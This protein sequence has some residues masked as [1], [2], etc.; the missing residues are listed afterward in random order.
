VTRV[1]PSGD[2]PWIAVDATAGANRGCLYCLRDARK[3][4]NV[5]TCA[6]GEPAGGFEKVAFP[7]PPG[8]KAHSSNLAL[9]SDGAVVWTVAPA[10]P[11]KK[12][13]PWMTVLLSG[14]GGHTVSDVGKVTLTIDSY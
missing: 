6:N 13:F 9:L 12:A 8:M 2:R 3:S 7:R 14:D 4:W 10:G 1:P 11:D 5:L